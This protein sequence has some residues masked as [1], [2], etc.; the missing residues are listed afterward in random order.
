MLRNSIPLM[1]SAHLLH[2][3]LRLAGTDDLTIELCRESSF[4]VMPQEQF[5][6]GTEL[7]SAYMYKLTNSVLNIWKKR[8][9]VLKSDNCLYYFKTNTVRLET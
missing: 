8:W 5:S 4:T 7:Y 9:F 1:L 2:Y 6:D 3:S